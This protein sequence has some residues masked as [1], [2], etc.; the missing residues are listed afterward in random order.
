[1][2][3]IPPGLTAGE[4]EVRTAS[5]VVATRGWQQPGQLPPCPAQD[6]PGKARNIKGFFFQLCFVFLLKNNLGINFFQTKVQQRTTDQAEQPLV[7]SDPAWLH[8]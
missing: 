1:M 3:V 2:H 5:R 7:V 6:I 4:L 8:G